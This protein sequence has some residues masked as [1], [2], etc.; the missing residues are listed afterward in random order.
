MTQ[1]IMGELLDKAGCRDDEGGDEN[2]GRNEPELA[3]SHDVSV[4]TTSTGASDA[5]WLG[6]PCLACSPSKVGYN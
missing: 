5:F 4:I 2:N 1:T 3:I 6:R